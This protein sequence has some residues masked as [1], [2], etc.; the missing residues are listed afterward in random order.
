MRFADLGY[1]MVRYLPKYSNSVVWF[2][3]CAIAISLYPIGFW[4]KVN[5]L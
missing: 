4:P 3:A 1:C 5:E 2:F